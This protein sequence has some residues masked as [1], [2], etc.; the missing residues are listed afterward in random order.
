MLKSEVSWAY[1]FFEQFLVKYCTKNLYSPTADDSDA[2]Q[3]TWNGVSNRF[4]FTNL[5]NFK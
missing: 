1:A 4:L 2:L 5:L 3:I